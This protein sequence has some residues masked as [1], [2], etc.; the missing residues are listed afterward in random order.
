MIQTFKNIYHAIAVWGDG[1]IQQNPRR[2]SILLMIISGVGFSSMGD[3]VVTTMQAGYHPAQ[4]A[5][6]RGLGA[7]FIIGAALYTSMRER[8]HKNKNT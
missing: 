8:T 1:I 4:V 5:F 6:L 2:A 3:T 7:G